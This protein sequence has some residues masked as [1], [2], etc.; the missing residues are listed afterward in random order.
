MSEWEA[1]SIVPTLGVAKLDRAVEFYE[2]I[3]FTVKWNYSESDPS[4]TNPSY[5]E[6][7]HV[8]LMFGRTSIMLTACANAESIQKQ[9]VYFVM[10][11]VKAFHAGLATVIEVPDLVDSDYGMTDFAVRDPWGHILT[12]GEASA[13]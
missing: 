1:L 13:G 10:K 3:G 11:G 6:S 4:A 12:F 9:G 5:D 7:S 8:G 2:S